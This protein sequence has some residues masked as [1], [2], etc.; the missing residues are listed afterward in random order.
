MTAIET[1]A[2][3]NHAM[4]WHERDLIV[5]RLR[6][7]LDGPELA[8]MLEQQAAWQGDLGY[9]L[10]VVDVHELSNATADALRAARGTNTTSPR[11]V[12]L[13]GAS[14]AIRALSDLLFRAKRALSHGAVQYRFLEDEAACFAWLHEVRPEMVAWAD[15]IP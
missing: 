13:V 4:E 15:K 14:F 5:Y 1:R 10:A 3:G 2:F 6:G 9:L 11:G 12:A 7:V 8:A